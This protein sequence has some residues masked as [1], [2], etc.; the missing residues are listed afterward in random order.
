MLLAAS[1]TLTS[2]TIQDSG[3]VQL[4]KRATTSAP[5][6]LMW[7]PPL[8]CEG[9]QGPFSFG[10]LGSGKVVLLDRQQA[11]CWS[12]RP[13]STGAG[14]PFSLVIRWAAGWGGRQ[15]QQCRRPAV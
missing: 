5:E 14:G 15:P 12:V 1:A 9:Q 3:T 8:R 2:L 10:V 13:A 6:Q 4:W 11:V 7:E